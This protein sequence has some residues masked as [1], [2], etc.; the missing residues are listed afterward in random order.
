MDLTRF[1]RLTRGRRVNGVMF[2]SSHVSQDPRNVNIET[3]YGMGWK[4]LAL[5][6]QSYPCRGVTGWD[7]RFLLYTLSPIHAEVLRDGMEGSCS[8]PSVLSRGVAG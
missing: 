5:Y 2:V 7:G 4:A 3:S 1:P 8:I 6:P